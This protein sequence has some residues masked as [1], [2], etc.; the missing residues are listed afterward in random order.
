MAHWWFLVHLGRPLHR[1]G[2][3]VR[4]L[5]ARPRAAMASRS[6]DRTRFRSMAFPFPSNDPRAVDL[7]PT[8]P[9]RTIKRRF[10]GRHPAPKPPAPVVWERNEAVNRSIRHPQQ[11]GRVRWSSSVPLAAALSAS[12]RQLVITVHR[13][14]G[15]WPC[16]LPCERQAC[17]EGAVL[18][19]APGR[20]MLG[21]RHFG[22]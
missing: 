12:R 6:S 7:S 22:P 16:R 9:R 3:R 2:R 15:R 10:I 5:R 8:E 19:P 17:R 21:L 13:S 20:A 1:A 4:V 18:D 14:P 11:E